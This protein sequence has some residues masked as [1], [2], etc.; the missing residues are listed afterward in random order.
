[1]AP[2]LTT[3]LEIDWYNVPC[4]VGPPSRITNGDVGYDNALPKFWENFEHQ[5]FCKQWP[6]TTN[7][8]RDCNCSILSTTLSTALLTFYRT[9]AVN[10]MWWYWRYY[11]QLLNVF[12]MGWTW[13]FYRGWPLIL[14]LFYHQAFI[15]L[16][17]YGNRSTRILTLR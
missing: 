8:G 9:W 14:W 13:K 1:M 4:C 6:A 11:G 17:R 15:R 7:Y 16:L 3:K 5:G 12:R 10:T 2:V